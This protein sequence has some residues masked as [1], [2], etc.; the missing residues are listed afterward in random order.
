MKR[1]QYIAA[2]AVRSCFV[3]DR[4]PVQAGRILYFAL[5]EFNFIPVIKKGNQFY[6]YS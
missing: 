6:L 3:L 1:L 5:D 2:G 4:A